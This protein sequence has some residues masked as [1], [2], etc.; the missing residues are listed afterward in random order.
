MPLPS[1]LS[2]A[3]VI[4]YLHGFASSPESSKA[5]YF[6]ERL[7][8]HGLT[9]T[10]PDLYEQEYVGLYTLVEQVNKSFAKE[11]LPGKTGLLLKPEGTVLDQAL[12]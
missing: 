10:V 1:R 3:A 7:H 9:L 12:L 5:A 4:A 8:G 6:R 11:F 2:D